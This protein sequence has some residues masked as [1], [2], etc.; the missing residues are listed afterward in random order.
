MYF[1]SLLIH[2]A[3][4]IIPAVII[5]ICRKK[6]MQIRKE[7]ERGTEKAFSYVRTLLL[8]MH[9]QTIIMWLFTCGVK[10]NTPLFCYRLM[11]TITFVIPIIQGPFQ[12]FTYKYTIE[13]F[14]YS[15]NPLNIAMP[16]VLTNC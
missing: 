6:G 9:H 11:F 12:P 5:I 16:N 14:E 7:V 8:V 1:Y 15:V 3:L 13:S 10:L 2:H 4:N